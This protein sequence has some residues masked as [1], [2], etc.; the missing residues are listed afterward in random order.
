MAYDISNL[1]TNPGVGER[2]LSSGN[3]VYSTPFMTE[4]NGIVEL[5]VYPVGTGGG[6]RDEYQVALAHVDSRPYSDSSKFV[7]D[8][9]VRTDN[10]TVAFNKA[11]EIV[12]SFATKNNS[13]EE[14][15]TLDNKMIFRTATDLPPSFN[16]DYDAVLTYLA[17]TTGQQMVVQ[18]HVDTG[19]MPYKAAHLP[20]G[21][22]AI[23][24]RYFSGVKKLE[25]MVNKKHIETG[26]EAVKAFESLFI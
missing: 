9:N 5:S 14:N 22:E 18:D 13:I 6:R 11:L 16:P 4:K 26:N 17:Q 3:T 20:S 21:E 24:L 19:G 2:V 25:L 7:T 15:G 23:R 12:R 10:P 8:E 1:M